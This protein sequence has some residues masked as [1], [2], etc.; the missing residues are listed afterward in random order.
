MQ[1]DYIEASFD[2]FGYRE[3][4]LAADLLKS[5]SNQPPEWMKDWDI[6]KVGF[7]ANNGMV[8]LLNEDGDV[9]V[10]EDGKLKPFATCDECDAEGTQES[11]EHAATCAVKK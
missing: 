5:Y 9:A 3:M 6:V 11:I 8:F 10:M 7:N 2:G 4:D 1:N